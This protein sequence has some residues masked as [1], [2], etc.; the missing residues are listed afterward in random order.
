MDSNF[1]RVFVEKYTVIHFFKYDICEVKK[2]RKCDKK[3]SHRNPQKISANNAIQTSQFAKK[4]Y[5]QIIINTICFFG[6]EWSA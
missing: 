6:S 1:L 5:Y 2:T 3:C 4:K